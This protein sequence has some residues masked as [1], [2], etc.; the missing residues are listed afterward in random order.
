MYAEVPIFQGFVSTARKVAD[1]FE[2]E[3][4]ERLSASDGERIVRLVAHHVGA[5]VH[6][7]SP[8][9]SAEL[10][11][12]GER[13]EDCCRQW[14]RPIEQGVRV[15]ESGVNFPANFAARRLRDS[16]Y[17]VFGARKVGAHRCQIQKMSPATRCFGSASCP[18]SS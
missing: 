7:G 1:A 16:V 17:D 14:S 5:E 8:R 3:T 10:P 11:E 2:R 15:G 9:V 4:I 6:A 18:C 12:T 13:F